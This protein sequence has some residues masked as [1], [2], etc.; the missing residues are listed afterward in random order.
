M[1][2]GY[3]MSEMGNLQIWYPVG[4][5]MKDI[6][7]MDAYQPLRGEFIRINYTKG[8]VEMLLKILEF[9]FLGDL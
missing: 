4:A 9:E 1:K 2:A 8:G 7:A 6:Q 5:F 3:Y